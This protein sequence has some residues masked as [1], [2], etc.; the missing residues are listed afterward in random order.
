MIKTWKVYGA[1]GHRQRESFR[2]SHFH[3]FSAGEVIRRIWVINSDQT[4]TND[5]T[6]VKIERNTLEECD[7]EFWGQVS[8]GIFENC[9]VGNIE[10]VAE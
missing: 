8:D 9:R 5:Y 7:R 3:D 10:E 6:I 1:V 2:P 4:E